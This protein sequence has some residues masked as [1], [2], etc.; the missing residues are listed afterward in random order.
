VKLVI[1]CE[2]A[3][4]DQNLFALDYFEALLDSGRSLLAWP[5]PK[6]ARQTSAAVKTWLSNVVIFVL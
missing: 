1:L 4:L 6:E 5:W 2:A 3:R